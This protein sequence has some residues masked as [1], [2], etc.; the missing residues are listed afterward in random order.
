MYILQPVAVSSGGVG[1][2]GGYSGLGVQFSASGGGETG[3]EGSR[4]DAMSSSFVVTSP[5]RH[6]LRHR[7]PG[8]LPIHE[9]SADDLDNLDD[10][11]CV[12]ILYMHHKDML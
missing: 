11:S 4:D 5:P 8:V 2:S 6:T 12:A 1:S 3:L 9:D 10:V 7:P